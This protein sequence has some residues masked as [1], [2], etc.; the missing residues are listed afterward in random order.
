[1]KLLFVIQDSH[2]WAG[3]ERVTNLIANG[4]SDR[5]EIEVLS[6]SERP[7]CEKGYLYKASIVR[8]YIPIHQGVLGL[9]SIN[10][11]T[12]RHI[13]RGA[14]DVVVIS[15]VGEIKFLLVA[16]LFCRTKFVAWEHFNAAYTHRRVN[17]KV[18]ARFC[19]AI[20]VLTRADAD[21]WQLYLHPR[22]HIVRIPNPLATIPRQPSLLTTTRVLALG[23][24][25]EQK[26]FDLL[27]DAFVLMHAKYPDWTL[28]IRGTGSKEAELKNRVKELGLE[29]AIEI[30]PAVEDVASEYQ[31]ASIYALSSKFEGFPMT[32]IEAMAFGIPCVSFDCPN[33]PSEIIAQGEDGFLVPYGDVTALAGA[34]AKLAQEPTLRMQ[35]GRKAREHIKRFDQEHVSALWEDFLAKLCQE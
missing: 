2:G 19:D 23:R 12:A 26:R 9:F 6:L 25:E 15:G 1:V 14:Y 27:I 17:R 4:L 35:M 33:G 16:I 31:V 30:L 7:S 34:L 28:R 24:L 18:A 13:S 3:T 32:L 5:Y 29:N 21:D 22:G 8:S 10:T 20:V 11:K